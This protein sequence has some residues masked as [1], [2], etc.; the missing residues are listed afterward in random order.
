M[1]IINSLPY[2]FNNHVISQHAPSVTSCMTSYAVRRLLLPMSLFVRPSRTPPL[3]SPVALATLV[4][5]LTF[6]LLVGVTEVTS[7]RRVGDLHGLLKPFKPT[8]GARDL[9]F[10]TSSLRQ[11]F[12][13]IV[14]PWA[15]VPSERRGGESAMTDDATPRWSGTDAGRSGRRWRLPLDVLVTSVLWCWSSFS[16]TCSCRVWLCSWAKREITVKQSGNN[17]GVECTAVEGITTTSHKPY[18]ATINI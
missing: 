1:C 2:L 12:P 9:P 5:Q 6:V 3:M 11:Q 10:V 14:A 4:E 17:D 16:W 13:A 8:G 18:C 15:H 7:V